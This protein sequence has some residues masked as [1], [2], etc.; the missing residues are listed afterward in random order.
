MKKFYF[1][2]VT[3]LTVASLQANVI[4]GNFSICLPGPNTT[5]LIASLPPAPITAS[6]PWFS[7]NTAVATISSTGLVTALN[8][9]TT[10]ISYTDNLGNTYSENVYV[11]AFPTVTAPNGTSTCEAGILQLEGSLF[12]NPINPWESLNP[13]IATVNNTGLVTGVSSGVANILYRNLGGCT[14][15]FP[16]TIN[17]SLFPT[18][19]CGFSTP[20][21]VTFNWNTVLGALSY[22]VYYTLNGGPLVFVGPT[23]ALTYTLSSLAPNDQIVLY[24]AP[25]GTVGNCYTVGSTSCS[26][27]ACPDAGMDGTIIICEIDTLTI[28]LFSLISEEDLGGV[29]TRSSG[30]GG[31]FDAALGTFTSS[32]ATTSTFTYTLIGSAPCLNDSSVATIDINQQ[33]NAGTDGAITICDSNVV[34]IDL[35][36]VII[37][38]QPLGTWSRIAGSGGIFDSI[39]GIYT[40]S[41]GATSSIFEYRLIST[42]PCEDDFSIVSI[43]INSQPN[44][45]V[46]GCISVSDESTTVIDL[47]ALISGGNSGGTWTRSSGTGGTFSALTG[48]YVPSIGATTST[49]TYSL[50][51]A[52]A[53]FDDISIVTVVLN[54]PPCGSLSAANF[55][56]IEFEYYPNPFNEI[57]NLKSSETISSVQ[58]SNILGQQV[59]SED[60]SEKNLQINLSH[61]SSGTYIVNA[62]GSD[63]IRTFKIV[64]N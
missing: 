56:T 8:F 7:L 44:A 28:D 51:G 55:N 31:L 14:S 6:T 64:K 16:I 11:S 52:P 47:F 41:F 53:C 49:F 40:P 5:Q 50:S 63:K 57:L 36:S 3:I 29:W 42:P 43:S 27:A 20:T 59:F 60:Y 45:G 17:P 24:V 30:T 37:G 1:L 2:I 13:D 25:S 58:I 9:G 4:T 46:D 34:P 19:T 23:P 22:A 61:L 26:S 54:G 39:A 62:I 21:S 38:E 32:N 12:P 33:F 35:F 18:I 48:T 10:T 15:T